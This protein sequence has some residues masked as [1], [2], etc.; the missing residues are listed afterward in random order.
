ME[1]TTTTTMRHKA[2]AASGTRSFFL[3]NKLTT[4]T[5]TSL[6]F[7]CTQLLLAQ[8]TDTPFTLP[9]FFFFFFYFLEGKKHKNY[10]PTHTFS[11]Q[12]NDTTARKKNIKTTNQHI[13][14]AYK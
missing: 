4:A 13:L 1:T 8:S 3:F 11:L 5:H 6:F 9:H 7:S 10:Q 12:I 14:L 2:V